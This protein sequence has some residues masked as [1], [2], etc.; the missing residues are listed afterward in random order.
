[1]Q[2][3]YI[4]TSGPDT[5]LENIIFSLIGLSVKEIMP[6]V[7]NPF[8]RNIRCHTDGVFAVFRKENIFLSGT[9]FQ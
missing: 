7:G 6:V 3:L 9:F 4:R 2:L 1:M 8:I 5:E